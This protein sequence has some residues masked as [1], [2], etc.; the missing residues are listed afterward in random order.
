MK[1]NETE[2]KAQ[3][4]VHNNSIKLNKVAKRDRWKKKDY[5]LHPAITLHLIF[6]FLDISELH[7]EKK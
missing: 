2:Q 5:L 6:D 1:N 7:G 3:K 4:L